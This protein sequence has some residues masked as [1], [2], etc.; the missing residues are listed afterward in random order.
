MFHFVADVSEVF[1]H[2]IE[3]DHASRV[4][5]VNIIVNSDAADVHPDLALF[6]GLEFLLPVRQCVVNR[7]RHKEHTMIGYAI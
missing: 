5:H 3:N 7:D 6:D 4:T 2:H 1:R